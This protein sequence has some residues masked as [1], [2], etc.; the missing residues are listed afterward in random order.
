MVTER[1]ERP[2]RGGEQE[3]RLSDFEPIQFRPR[4]A[5]PPSAAGAER[6]SGP[7][8]QAPPITAFS[9]QELNEILLLYGR[10]VAAGE[11]RDYTLDMGRDQA[12]FSVFRRTSE[13]PLYRIEKMPRNARRQ[14]QYAVVAASGLVVKRG[15]D[16]RRVLDVLEKR[17]RIVKG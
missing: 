1:P 10:K 8:P 9:R 7:L 16:L 5:A 11:W 15:H 12:V 2:P 13:C 3:A 6:Q 4:P 14:G 17:V